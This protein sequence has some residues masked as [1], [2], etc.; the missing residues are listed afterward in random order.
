[1][2]SGFE[3]KKLYFYSRRGIIEVESDYYGFA[4]GARE[5]NRGNLFIEGDRPNRNFLLLVLLNI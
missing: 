2:C 5:R 3:D 4:L 1:M